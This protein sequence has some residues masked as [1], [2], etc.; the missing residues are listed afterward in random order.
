MSK[1]V[2]PSACPSERTHD[3][4]SIVILLQHTIETHYCNTLLQHTNVP[5]MLSFYCDTT[6]THYC[7]TLLQH[8][9]ATHYCNTLTCPRCRLYCDTTVTHYRNTLLQHTTAT[10]YCNTLTCPRCH[11]YCDTR[12]WVVLELQSRDFGHCGHKLNPSLSHVSK[13]VHYQ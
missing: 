3:V 2:G 8:T 4:T 1:I 11:F 9:A 10:H 5:M 7:N 6:A 13:I 12:T